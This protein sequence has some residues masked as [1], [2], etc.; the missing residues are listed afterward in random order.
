MYDSIQ[1][2]V[3][4]FLTENDDIYNNYCSMSEYQDISM[5]EFVYEYESKR[6]YDYCLMKGWDVEL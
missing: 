3:F 2:A 5:V 6:F 4:W 1:E